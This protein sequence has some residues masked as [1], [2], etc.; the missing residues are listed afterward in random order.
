MAG[1]HYPARHRHAHPGGRQP[2]GAP[3]LAPENGAALA[4]SSRA[5]RADDAPSCK[6]SLSFMEHLGGGNDRLRTRRDHERVRECVEGV[7]LACRWCSD[8]VRSKKSCFAP[9]ISASSSIYRR[10]AT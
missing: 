1:G 3:L 2:L 8:F 10:R 6:R 4:G 5:H 9:S 7:Q